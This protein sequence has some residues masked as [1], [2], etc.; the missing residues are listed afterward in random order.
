MSFIKSFFGEKEKTE[1]DN[2]LKKKTEEISKKEDLKVFNKNK[3]FNFSN[4]GDTSINFGRPKVR[5][6]ERSAEVKNSTKVEK[7]LKEKIIETKLETTETKKNIDSKLES[8]TELASAQESKAVLE[9]KI[10][11][12]VEKKIE[13]IIPKDD[14]KQYSPILNWAITRPIEIAYDLDIRWE[15]E[16]DT[17]TPDKKITDIE[18]V[19]IIEQ[20]SDIKYLD[21]SDCH[22]IENFS[23]LGKMEQLEEL[24]LC[25]NPQL[26]DISFLANLKNLKVLNLGSTGIEDIGILSGL[27]NLQVLNLKYNYLNSLD[28]VKTLV[29]LHDLV[30]WGCAGIDTVDAVA[31]LKELRDL[32]LDSS[33][34]K[35][36]D[37]IAGLTKMDTLILDN[38]RISDISPIKDLVNLRC[39]T[40]EVKSI[41]S[42][43]MFQ[44][45]E[46]LTELRTLDL[47]NRG[48]KDISL[49]K[50]MKHLLDLQLDSNCV[51]DVSPLAGLTE[52]RKLLL[53]G[54]KALT[55]LSVLSELTKMECFYIDGDSGSTA[56]S[57]MKISDFSFMN[58]WENM[59]EFS[60]GHNSSLRDISPF[61]NLKKLVILS[62]SDCIQVED[63]S[64]LRNLTD[65]SIL[66]FTRCPRIS[67]ISCLKNLINMSFLLMDGTNVGAYAL[68]DLKNL[69]GAWNISFNTSSPAGNH[70]K[71]SF[72]RK[73][74]TNK[75]RVAG[76]KRED[77]N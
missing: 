3:D 67:D 47:T 16:G 52:L 8:T 4:W 21:L 69:K 62:I 68:S 6:S 11:K 60:C 64:P 44:N 10:M 35:N 70:V 33:T 30:L 32:D 2:N 54:N 40:M 57:K 36:I 29:N 18:I 65:L 31:N 75:I 74:K 9:P 45:F 38:C 27:T 58:K 22:R 41:M 39:F 55:D 1:K 63:L 71:G 43:T 5:H 59:V 37:G 28:P 42:Q 72:A 34:I 66:D 19:K 12:E 77:E 53:S 51:V 17:L 56:T 49:L 24:S 7:S 26:E 25:N 20:N 15:F 76:E 48:I 14:K 61:A 46:K 50:N 73:R 23:F 13:R